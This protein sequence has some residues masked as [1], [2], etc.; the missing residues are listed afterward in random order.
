MFVPITTIAYVVSLEEAMQL[1]NDSTYGL[2]AGFY[3]SLEETS[4]FFD[5]IQA[6]VTYANRPPGGGPPRPGQAS[7]L[8]VAG[9]VL[10]LAERTQVVYTIYSFTCM[11]RSRH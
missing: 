8:S 4:W 6:G 1:A 7:N 9:R 2:T 5:A 3:G 10:V 11:N